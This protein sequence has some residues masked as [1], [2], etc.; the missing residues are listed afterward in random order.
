MVE[1]TLMEPPRTFYEQE[2]HEKCPYSEFFWSAFSRIWT[3]YGEIRSIPPYSVRMRGITYQR[4]SKY[5]HF[6]CGGELQKKNNNK[7]KKINK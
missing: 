1:T 5:G 4:N 6:L 2:L 3:K 7:I